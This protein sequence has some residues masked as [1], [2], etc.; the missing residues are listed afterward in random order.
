MAAEGSSHCNVGFTGSY[1]ALVTPN[2]TQPFRGLNVNL[3]L[4]ALAYRVVTWFHADFGTDK[5]M[6][7]CA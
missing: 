4:T 1:W 7:S 6:C 3:K 2:K 5:N